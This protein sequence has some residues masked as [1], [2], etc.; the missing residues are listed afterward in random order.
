M[1]NAEQVTA[2]SDGLARKAANT[3]AIYLHRAKQEIDTTFGK[4][5]AE[6]NPEL[7]AAFITACASDIS[8]ATLSLVATTLE[9]KS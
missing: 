9:S 4:G 5:Y 2:D 8:S 7:V 3:T 6:N 1:T